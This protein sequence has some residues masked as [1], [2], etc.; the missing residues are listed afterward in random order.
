MDL[1]QDD[2]SANPSK[3][4]SP[5][6]SSHPL[7]AAM[8]ST[9]F[10]LP[11]PSYPQS[12]VYLLDHQA[13]VGVNP[14]DISVWSNNVT[15][16][17]EAGNE[18]YWDATSGAVTNGVIA[19]YPGHAAHSQAHL[20]QIHSPVYSLH[21]VPP[22]SPNRQAQIPSFPNDSGPTAT[23][24]DSTDISWNLVPYK[25]P[26]PG[27]SGAS[28]VN[29]AASQGTPS[30]S[31]G[32]GGLFL[33]SPTP[34]KRQRTSQA[35][36]K[37]RERKAKCNGA[38][39]TCQRCAARG[40]PC[41]YAKE[42]RLRGPSKVPNIQS[43]QSSHQRTSSSPARSTLSKS[44]S[45]YTLV[46]AGTGQAAST[47][48]SP[49][50]PFQKQGLPGDA[51]GINLPDVAFD[52]TRSQSN[53]QSLLPAQAARLS[54]TI[55]QYPRARSQTTPYPISCAAEFYANT[56]GGVSQ[57]D[58][59]SASTEASVSEPPSATEST[60]GFD[61]R[62]LYT[63]REHGGG[64]MINPLPHPT[65]AEALRPTNAQQD[66]GLLKPKFEAYDY[67]DNVLQNQGGSFS[68]IPREMISRNTTGGPSIS[69]S[70]VAHPN[71][72]SVYVE[73]AAS[74]MS[75]NGSG[76]DV[77]NDWSNQLL[78]QDISRSQSHSA[79]PEHDSKSL[80]VPSIQASGMPI[81]EQRPGVLPSPS[82]VS[83]SSDSHNYP[84]N[85]TPEAMEYERNGAA[86][87][88]SNEG[89]QVGR[90]SSSHLK[91]TTSGWDAAEGG[92]EMDFM[93]KQVDVAQQVR[94]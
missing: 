49:S 16:R 84:W 27:M 14:A 94:P 46:S 6:K 35:C 10:A 72:N 87:P 39:P 50:D 66:H 26:F 69:V 80:F 93:S 59:P 20:D 77:L 1:Y 64:H 11:Q 65:Q 9:V 88:H 82:G 71:P 62:H 53:L 31:A 61:S 92:R 23:S 15:R 68:D 43:T 74:N 76:F 41:E 24:R 8:P 40:L 85:F 51:N 44:S 17:H 81:T 73:E 56:S 47:N 34:T 37:C 2:P 70:D 57:G 54:S 30:G 12:Y 79:T 4:N 29:G 90:H 32:A 28:G 67:E 25:L 19:D 18:Q 5:T 22:P 91:D 78:Y 60:F 13:N 75:F 89:T 38:R 52:Q 55:S 7:D 45:T 36:E 86:L 33:R 42:R 58:S 3:R 83:L 21:S 48:S 63:Y